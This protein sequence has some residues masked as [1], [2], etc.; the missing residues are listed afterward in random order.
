MSRCLPFVI[1]V[2][3]G[4]AVPGI[5]QQVVT[6]SLGMEFVLI[7]PGS[8]T[9]GEF[10][11]P[12][13]VPLDTVKGEKRP[14]IMY[15]GEGRTYNASE[16]AL[17]KTL[18]MRD[19][20]EGIRVKIKKAYYLSRHEVTQAQWKRIMGNNPSSFSEPDSA[21][22]PVEGVTW[23]DT[24]A[25][26]ANLNRLEPGSKY[27]LPTEFEWEYAARA[28]AR[29]DI[30]WSSIEQLANLNKTHTIAVGQKQPNAWGLYDMLGNVW[31]WVDDYYN[32]SLFAD[33]RPPR[34]GT[35][36]VLKGASFAG[37]VKNATYMTHAAGP[38]NGWDVGFRIVREQP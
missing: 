33:R 22:R 31:E 26:I 29:G 14:S 11:P 30:P 15:M 34:R 2:W 12:Y 35:E 37:D 20:R 3:W 24:Q 28:G 1:L 36:H 19:T 16:F 21:N 13:P 38:G 27:R 17:A 5:A 9:V 25:F 7:Q 18:A 23:S 10:R 6:N 8:M 4:I 32:E